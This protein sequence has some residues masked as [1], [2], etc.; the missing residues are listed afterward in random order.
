[1]TRASELA[2]AIEAQLNK[3]RTADGFHHD[4]DRVYGFG[5]RKPDNV[6]PPFILIRILEDRTDET[7]G[8]AANRVVDYE[9]EG[10]MSRSSELRDLQL[11][12]HD[13]MRSLGLGQ[14]THIRPIKPGFPF[15][16]STEFEPDRDGQPVRRLISTVTFRYVEKY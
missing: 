10:V 14:F 5:Q 12:H 7:A 2:D 1:M 6:A 3:I 11:L 8:N 4:I 16:E 13:I 15:E 9:I